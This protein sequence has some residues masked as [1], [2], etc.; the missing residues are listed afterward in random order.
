MPVWKGIQTEPGVKAASSFAISWDRRGFICQTVINGCRE[1]IN[2]QYASETYQFI[3]KPPGTS[4]WANRLGKANIDFVVNHYGSLKGKNILEIGAGSLYLAER[5]VHDYGVAKYQV[6]DPAVKEISRNSRID[7]IRDYFNKESFKDTNYDLIMSFSCLEHVLDPI[8]FLQDIHSLL[9]VCSGKAVLVFPD[10]QQQFMDGD[11]N[12]L[13]HEHLSYFSY[14]MARNVLLRCGFSIIKG[15]SDAGCLRFLV[16]AQENCSPDLPEFVPI[17][18][19]LP[20]AAIHFEKNFNYANEN[21]RQA[22]EIGETIAF[23]G[24]TNGLNNFLFLLGLS[25]F[26]GFLLFD[27]DDSKTGKYLPTCKTSIRNAKDDSYKKA[28]KVFISAGTFFDEIK[29]SIM[30]EH[31]LTTEQIV[32]LFCNQG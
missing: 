11:L 8:E 19:I 7:V 25:D 22:L 17:D 21:I 31:S 20:L 29:Q 15:Q 12:A 6:V 4:D 13:L 5:F 14:D 26:D 23:H 10:I 3:T 9:I 28:D 32:P 2:E 16:Q 18:P 27:G 24:A 1:S 30:S